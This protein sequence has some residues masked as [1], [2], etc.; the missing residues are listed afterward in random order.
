VPYNRKRFLGTYRYFWD[1][2]GGVPTDWGTHRFDVMQL[3]MDVTAPTA[4]SASGA[5][6]ALED[7][8]EIPDVLQ[9]TFEYPGFVLSYECSLLNAFGT[10]GRT[11]GMKYYRANGPDDRPNG[12]AFYGTNGTL[13]ADRWGFEIMPELQP[14]RKATEK[15]R[16]SPDHFRMKREHAFTPDSTKLHVENFFEC[17]RTRKHPVADVELGHQASNV[18]HL[19]NIAY[20]TGRKLRWDAAQEQF[21]E[22]ETACAFLHRDARK[23]WDLI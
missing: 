19:A 12:M 3:I 5:R 6:F 4:V 21:I 9:A 11:P 22:D 10:G 18:A 17:I 8:G 2:A 1:Y 15:D 7:A 23:P 13:F 16:S 14:G 20:K